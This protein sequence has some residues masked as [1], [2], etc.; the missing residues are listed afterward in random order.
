MKTDGH[1][2]SL[3]QEMSEMRQ[4]ISLHDDHMAEIKDHVIIL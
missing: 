4:Q 3:S 1:A 2:T